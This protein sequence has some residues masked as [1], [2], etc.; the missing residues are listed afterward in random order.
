MSSYHTKFVYNGMDSLV[1]YGLVIVSFE[2]DNGFTDSFLSMDNIS[3][4]YYDG[5][6]RFDYGAKYSATSEIQITLIKKNGSDIKLGEFRECARWLTGTK[7][8]SWLDMY[9]GNDV[10]YS[11]LGKFTN[12]EQHKLDART[13]G[14]RLTFSSISPWAYSQP[15]PFNCDIGQSIIINEENILDKNQEDAP[16]FGVN[17]GVLHTNYLDKNSYFNITDAGVIYMD[18]SYKTKIYNETD[19]LYTYIYID[20][21]YVNDNGTEFLIKNVTLGEETI[22]T[23]ISPGET[24]SLSE[25][26]FIIS[27]IPNKIFG[28][29]FNFIWPRLCPG[30]NELIVY[31]TGRGNASF[32]YRYPMKVGD[33]VIDTGILG[34]LG[35]DCAGSDAGN[36]GG[37]CS[38][39]EQELR[40]MLESIF[41]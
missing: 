5:T 35:C 22:V 7:I 40:E 28:D 24:I 19:D 12:L 26:Q 37:T 32:T 9:V 3:D 29:N 30:T 34:Y 23:G 14:I 13:V 15:I 25:K 17:N 39:D 36:N 2:P 41:G 21:D 38:V 1:D 11:F 8:N 31:G 6:K 27:S 16:K 20:V 18:T 33:C 4:D 10:V